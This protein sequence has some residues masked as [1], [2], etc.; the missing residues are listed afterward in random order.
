MRR[1]TRS[2]EIAAWLLVAGIPVTLF[3]PGCQGRECE[4]IGFTDY[5]YGPG[6]GHLIDANTWES[7]PNDDPNQP[8]LSFGPYQTWVFHP[9]GLEG[10]DLVNVITYVSADPDPNDPGKN[11]TLAA[12]NLAEIG[13]SSDSRA[14]FV[15]NATCDPHYIRIVIVADPAQPNPFSGVE[16]G[17]SDAGDDSGADSGFIDLDAGDGGD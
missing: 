11:Y 14:V 13:A 3:A 2:L 17:V 15:T 6:Q 8:W 4:S 1:L 9:V 16:A 7:T 5:G 10:R 12:G